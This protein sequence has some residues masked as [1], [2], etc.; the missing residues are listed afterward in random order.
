MAPENYTLD[1][2][3]QNFGPSVLDFARERATKGNWKGELEMGVVKVG[4]SQLENWGFG[5][6]ARR[7]ARREHTENTRPVER[8]H[9]RFGPRSMELNT[10]S[11]VHQV[12]ALW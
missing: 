12:D 5:P 11:M 9:R 2:L 8:A 7:D 6:R 1:F 10:R 4:L 3:H